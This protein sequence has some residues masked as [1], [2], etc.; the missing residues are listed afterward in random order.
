M[1]AESLRSYFVS[2]QEQ[3]SALEAL[4]DFFDPRELDLYDA[5]WCA[6][7][8]SSSAGEALRHFNK[9]YDELGEFPV[10]TYSVLH[11]PERAAGRP[12]RF[13]TRSTVNSP[14]S[15]GAALSTC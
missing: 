15:L 4:G 2:D 10:G 13:S 14:S 5:S 1:R 8:P 3:R 12:K 7:N 11:N 9:I 6:F